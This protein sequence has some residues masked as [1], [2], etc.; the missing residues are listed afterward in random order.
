MATTPTRAL[1]EPSDRPPLDFVALAAVGVDEAP[2]AVAEDEALEELL[3]LE[4]EL[5]PALLMD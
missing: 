1:D 3:V 2:L 5:L 4:L